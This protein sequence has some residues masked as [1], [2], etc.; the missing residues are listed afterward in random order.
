M[1]DKTKEA[2]KLALDYLEPLARQWGIESKA[3]GVCTA[4]RLA[5]TEEFL[6]TEQPAQDNTYGYAKSLAETIFKQHFARDEHYA[7][8]R[9]VWEVNNTVI[10]ILTQIDNMVADM[11]RRPAIK[12]DLTPEQ[13]AHILPNGLTEAETNATASVIGLVAQQVLK[14]APCQGMNCGITRTDQEHS[15]EC[16][17]EHA[18]TIAGGKFVKPTPVAEPRKPQQEPVA[19]ALQFRSDGRLCLSTVFDTMAE[20]QEYASE[21]SSKPI[22]VP[23][24]TSPP[25]Q[26]KPWM[27]LTDEEVMVIAF[28]FDVPSLVVRTVEAKLKEKND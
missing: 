13:P 12:Q 6:S 24:Y 25:A 20:A 14:H 11:V 23:L 3:H 26:R 28:D 8:G 22:A 4:I 10:G 21:C 5:L 16:Q 17:A 27:G 7:S 2:L 1:T 19:V 15:P 18:A 9:I